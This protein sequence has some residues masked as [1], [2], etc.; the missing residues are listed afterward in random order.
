[1]FSQEKFEKFRPY[2]SASEA[3]RDHHNHTEIMVRN[4]S[5]TQAIHHIVVSQSPFLWNKPFIFEALPHSYL[6]GAADLSTLFAGHEAMIY[7]EMCAASKQLFN[8]FLSQ[9]NLM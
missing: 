2:E 6:L 5:V 4:W 3:V 7:V 9:S 1:M 8:Q